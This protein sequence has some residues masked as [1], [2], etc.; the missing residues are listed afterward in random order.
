MGSIQIPGA[1]AQIPLEELLAAQ[2]AASQ[3][4]NIFEGALRVNV[5]L[6]LHLVYKKFYR[7]D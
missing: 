1:S 3:F 2:F 5:N 4:M 6:F 7:N